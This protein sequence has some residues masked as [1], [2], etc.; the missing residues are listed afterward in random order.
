MTGSDSIGGWR[1][2]LPR[3]GRLRDDWDMTNIYTEVFETAGD[4]TTN[5]NASFVAEL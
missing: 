1:R 3:R 5:A 2:L 4:G